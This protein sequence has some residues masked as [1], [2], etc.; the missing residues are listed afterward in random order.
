MTSS[1]LQVV[2][3]VSNGNKRSYARVPA[4]LDVPNLIQVQVESFDWLKTEGLK[5]LFEEVSPIED[6]P[7]GRFELSFEDHYFEA[8]KNTEGECKDKEN[9]LL[10]PSSCHRQTQDKGCGTRPG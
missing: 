8:P 5:Q 4:V 3:G 9:H 6:F 1:T 7:G 10:R 2:N